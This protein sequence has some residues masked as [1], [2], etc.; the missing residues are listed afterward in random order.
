MPTALLQSRAAVTTTTPRPRVRTYPL[1]EPAGLS[2]WR[3]EAALR[4]VTPPVAPLAA[5]R[6]LASVR[7][8]LPI[9]ATQAVSGLGRDAVMDVVAGVGSRLGQA[10]KAGPRAQACMS[11]SRGARR[12][13]EPGVHVLDGETFV[14][15][16]DGWARTRKDPRDVSRSFA[17]A[18]LADERGDSA[19]IEKW[20]ARTTD[21]V[22]PTYQHLAHLFAV[23]NGTFA[24]LEGIT[25]DPQVQGAYL[26]AFDLLTRAVRAAHQNLAIVLDPSSNPAQVYRATRECF[27]LLD[28]FA[29]PVASRSAAAAA[30]ANTDTLRA[31][32]ASVERLRTAVERTP[33]RFFPASLAGLTQSQ[34]RAICAQAGLGVP[35]DDDGARDGTGEH[36]LLA[37]L[38]TRRSALSPALV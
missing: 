29:R 18:A 33:R 24:T 4:V 2:T 12:G 27:W 1:Q 9:A 28:G 16:G 22:Q 36:A 15:M 3:Q 10:N 34:F 20:L 35:A 25:T 21:E 17:A 23:A 26:R 5:R 8:G 13:L 30:D 31:L 7:A 6:V 14:V 19:A 32:R 38:R 11:F 37:A